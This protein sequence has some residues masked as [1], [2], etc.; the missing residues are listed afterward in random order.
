[1][2]AAAVGSV[3]ELI[4]EITDHRGLLTDLSGAGC[5]YEL[6]DSDGT[7]IFGDGTYANAEA[8]TGAGMT[9]VS[10]VDHSGLT[11]GQYA[12]YVW[13]QDG[14]QT[15]RRGPYWYKVV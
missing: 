1:M 13:F 4:V 7:F 9:V 11:P 14:T 8:A 10:E 6:T 15:V 3:E 2:I 12:L 5:K